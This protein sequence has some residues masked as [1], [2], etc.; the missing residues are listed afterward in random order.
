LEKALEII[1][2]MTN[3]Y[4]VPVSRPSFKVLQDRVFSALMRTA[5]NLPARAPEI[6]IGE[7]T[8]VIPG[9]PFA[10]A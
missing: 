4:L 2:E 9:S 1:E 3:G 6:I 8:H 5:L 10:H 7:Q